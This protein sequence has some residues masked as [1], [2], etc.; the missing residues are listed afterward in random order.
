M[1]GDRCSAAVRVF[2]ISLKIAHGGSRRGR[3]PETRSSCLGDDANTASNRCS[4]HCD[5]IRGP[6]D[7]L[8]VH[9]NYALMGGEALSLQ[10]DR[11]R[12]AFRRLGC[13]K[14]RLRTLPCEPA[15]FACP[16]A[17]RSPTSPSA[18]LAPGAAVFAFVR[19]PG[20]LRP[21]L[22]LRLLPLGLCAAPCP[23]AFWVHT[24]PGG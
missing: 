1:R 9:R 4:A 10:P 6:S 21:A 2:E 12:L 14:T 7:A 15:C 13:R 19:E 8:M 17:A 23:R 11:R 24:A 22:V 18:S 5:L 20:R 3:L 16:A